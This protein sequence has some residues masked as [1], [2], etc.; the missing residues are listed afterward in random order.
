MSKNSFILMY[1]GSVKEMQDICIAD[2]LMG[3][4]STPRNVLY[5]LK[6]YDKIYK[7]IPDDLSLPYYVSCSFIFAQIA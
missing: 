5:V 6:K 3:D 1:D 2:K 7:I 4:D